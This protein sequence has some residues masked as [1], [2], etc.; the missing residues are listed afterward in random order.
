M[1][2]RTGIGEHA[3]RQ[4]QWH[5]W[6]ELDADALTLSASTQTSSRRH[7]A[8]T[9]SLRILL[10]CVLFAAFLVLACLFGW[11]VPLHSAK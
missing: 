4:P 10:A 7:P 1:F 5:A 8:T 6:K 11:L 2:G 9:R 3:S